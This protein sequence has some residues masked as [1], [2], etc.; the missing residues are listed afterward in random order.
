MSYIQ[1]Q[2]HVQPLDTRNEDLYH[3][4]SDLANSVHQHSG[5][6]PWC[7]SSLSGTCEGGG[8]DEIRLSQGAGWID[9][10]GWATVQALRP[11]QLRTDRN[12]LGYDATAGWPGRGLPCDPLTAGGLRL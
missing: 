12:T 3:S 10:L 11:D 7:C 8:V 5:G 4:T 9:P 2:S 6:R 1:S